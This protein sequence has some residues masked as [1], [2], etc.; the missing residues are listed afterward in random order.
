MPNLPLNYQF[1]FP[2]EWPED[3]ERSAKT[4]DSRFK[5]TPGQARD[6]MIEQLRLMG[7][8][9]VVISCNL[10]A[11]RN[12][13]L[14]TT[15]R[16]RIDDPAVAVYFTLYERDF[17]IPCDKYRSV[18][19]NMRG[20]GLSIEAMRT[21][22]RHATKQIMVRSFTGLALPERAK[23]V[24]QQDWR[25]TL[26]VDETA[27]WEDIR[28]GYR[29]SVKMYHHDGTMPDADKYARIQYAFELAKRHFNQ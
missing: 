21:I 13:Q 28:R 20:I 4:E 14:L 19:D 25:V 12:G 7:A 18:W 3:W 26:G 9:D 8:R 23:A 6:E 2:L 29:S 16:T 17:V 22:E 27:G 24:D 15:Q 1:G 5:V 10:P 11:S